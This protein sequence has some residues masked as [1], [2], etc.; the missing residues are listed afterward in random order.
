MD[1]QNKRS[2][3]ISIHG[4]GEDSS[5]SG[6]PKIGM[7]KPRSDLREELKFG[8]R[9]V[10]ERSMLPVHELDHKHKTIQLSSQ[11]TRET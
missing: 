6:L 5:T 10:P 9:H 4:F 2:W 1:E 11:K 3:I 8:G 7:H